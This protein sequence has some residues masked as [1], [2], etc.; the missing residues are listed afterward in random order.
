MKR[1]PRKDIDVHSTGDIK[2]DLTKEQL[3]AFGAAALAYNMLEDQIDALL[4]VVTRVPDWLF[5]EVSSRIHGLD[6][7]TA[8][9]NKGLARIG[10]APKD[11][12]Y[13]QEGLATFGDFKKN[14][15]AMIHARIVN[16]SAG[17]GLSAKQRGTAFEVLLSED[18]LA[19]FYDHIVAL[20]KLLSTGCSLVNG[21]MT[22][23]LTAADDPNKIT[24]RRS[25]SSSSTSIP[26]ESQPST[27]I[28]ANAK[29]PG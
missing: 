20:E 11:L 14:R 13:L 23:N 25:S 18:A 21:I 10:L 17:I 26:G 4:F 29:I 9:I 5:A 19:V 6:G 12:K 15:D 28:E 3:S 7:K 1:K 16:A 27:I 22:L 8:I 24:L 2:K